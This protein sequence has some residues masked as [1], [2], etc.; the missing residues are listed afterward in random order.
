MRKYFEIRKRYLNGNLLCFR[1]QS[2]SGTRVGA[3][4]GLTSNGKHAH[5]HNVTYTPIFLI[6]NDN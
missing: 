6:F 5:V 2:I 1:A 3:G 4:V